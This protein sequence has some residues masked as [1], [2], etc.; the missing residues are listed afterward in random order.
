MPTISF[1]IPSANVPEVKAAID[2]HVGA[3]A[4][5]GWTDQNYL[6]WYKDRARAQV[7]NLVIKYR[8]AQQAAVGQTDPTTD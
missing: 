1:Q 4:T 5:D 7:K 2:H 3:E 6:D 8:E